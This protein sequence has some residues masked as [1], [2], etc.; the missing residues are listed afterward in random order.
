MIHGRILVSHQAITSWI[1]EALERDAELRE[2]PREPS[3]YTQ[4]GWS[5]ICYRIDDQCQ[6]WDFGKKDRQ[7][8]ITHMKGI[9][10]E[11]YKFLDL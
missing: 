8:L 1:Q 4:T 3:E 5:L 10:D 11:L 2:N 9:Y 7:L 6:R